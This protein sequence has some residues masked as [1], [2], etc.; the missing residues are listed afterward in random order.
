MPL[1]LSYIH[2]N[3]RIKVTS[4]R[5]ICITLLAGE[6]LLL[7]TMTMLLSIVI[8]SF[9]LIAAGDNSFLDNLDDEDLSAIRFRLETEKQLRLLQNNDIEVMMLKLANIERLL[10]MSTDGKGKFVFYFHIYIILG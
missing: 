7:Y 6:E 8:S 10:G 4:K 1:L 5:C 2:I 3:R 9:I